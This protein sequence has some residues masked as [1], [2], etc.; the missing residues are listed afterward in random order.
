MFRDRRFSHQGET[1]PRYAGVLWVAVHLRQTVGPKSI[2]AGD[3]G[4]AREEEDEVRATP[5]A[6]DTGAGQA[7]KAWL[8]GRK[9]ALAGDVDGGCVEREDLG[10]VIDKDVCV[11]FF[12]AMRGAAVVAWHHEGGRLGGGA[13]GPLVGWTVMG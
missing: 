3:T 10:L 12:R 6:V 5:R 4:P 11:L 9:R 7:K 13:G 8:G 1:K 2:A